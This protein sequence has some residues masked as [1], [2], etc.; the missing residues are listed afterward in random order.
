METMAQES[1]ETC[2]QMM[3]LQCVNSKDTI[4]PHQYGMEPGTFLN[5]N[6]FFVS[7]RMSLDR[8]WE[9]ILTTLQKKDALMRKEHTVRIQDELKMSLEI[10]SVVNHALYIN[11]LGFTKGTAKGRVIPNSIELSFDMYRHIY[12][13][14]KNATKM[15]IVLKKA[16]NA[17][18]KKTDTMN[19]IENRFEEVGEAPLKDDQRKPLVISILPVNMMEHHEELCE[20]LEKKIL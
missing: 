16:G 17:Q 10:Y 11:L 18:T 8:R 6:E 14:G 9:L 4:R 13:K 2:D 20:E 1:S 19:E 15:N 7:Y 12:Q 5:W 3:S